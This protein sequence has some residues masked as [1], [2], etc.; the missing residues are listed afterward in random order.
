MSLNPANTMVVLEMIEAGHSNRERC[1]L[2]VWIPPTGPCRVMATRPIACGHQGPFNAP[3]CRQLNVVFLRSREQRRGPKYMTAIS[4]SRPGR[5]TQKCKEEEGQ[6]RAQNSG[7][8]VDTLRWAVGLTFHG[9][10]LR[11]HEMKTHN[12]TRGVYSIT[13]VG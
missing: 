7:D 8:T 13:S 9:F 12:F 4:P 11:V 2:H 10:M 5:S 1:F 6:I 3:M